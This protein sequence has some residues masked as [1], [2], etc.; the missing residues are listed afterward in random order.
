MRTFIRDY[1]WEQAFQNTDT[2]TKCDHFKAV[3]NSAVQHFVPI[4]AKKRNRKPR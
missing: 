2:N 3:V 4:L 1:D